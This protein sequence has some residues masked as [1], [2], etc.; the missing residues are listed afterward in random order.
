GASSRIE[1][2]AGFPNV[3]SGGDLTAR[4]A[5]QAQRLGAWLVSPC[6]VSGL[7]LEHGFHVVSLIDGSEVP[8]R[9]VVIATGA[10]Y[11]R[12]AISNLERFEGNGVYYAATD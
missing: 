3:I 6:E 10:R 4:T 12:L 11:Q 1:N 9:A 2:Y 7:R 8:A 5:I